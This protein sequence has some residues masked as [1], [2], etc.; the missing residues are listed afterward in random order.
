MFKP[1]NA[2][3]SDTITVSTKTRHFKKKNSLFFQK[4]KNSWPC[5]FPSSVP[6]FFSPFSISFS[7]SAIG[8][9]LIIS[10]GTLGRSS[11]S[12]HKS[13]EYNC[14]LDPFLI[15]FLVKLVILCLY[16]PNLGKMFQSLQKLEHFLD[17]L[18]RRKDEILLNLHENW[19][20]VKT[21]FHFHDFQNKKKWWRTLIRWLGLGGS[22]LRQSSRNSWEAAS[23]SCSVKIEHNWGFVK[24]WKC[25]LER[26]AEEIR[27]ETGKTRNRSN[28]HT[29]S[30]W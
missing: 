12:R 23:D 21:A 6:S 3:R 29:D 26:W 20:T 9:D 2:S 25:T 15:W 4:F 18:K 13:G 19:R 1:W 11:N 7:A 24:Y 17:E 28:T 22:R 27:N 10:N 14:K 30:K 8:S 5:T 16:S